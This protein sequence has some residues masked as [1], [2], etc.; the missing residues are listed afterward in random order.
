MAQRQQTK[1]MGWQSAGSME[2]TASLGMIK[3]TEE[4]EEGGVREG[5]KDTTDQRQSP[6]WLQTHPESH[7]PHWCRIII[8]DK[9]PNAPGLR[10]CSVYTVLQTDIH[11]GRH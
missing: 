3:Q 5:G 4:G 2:E 11:K 1:G 6:L 8:I 10:D 9:H 7:I